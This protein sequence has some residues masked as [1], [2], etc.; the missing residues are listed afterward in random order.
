MYDLAKTYAAKA[1]TARKL[2]Y[3]LT[4][5]LVAFGNLVKLH[6]AK[7][8]TA[9]KLAYELTARLVALKGECIKNV[10]IISGLEAEIGG[11]S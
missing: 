7:A 3:E 1:A 11:N 8:A 10:I 4:A 5:R 9:R 2:A 6:A